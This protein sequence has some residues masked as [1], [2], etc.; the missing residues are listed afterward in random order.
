MS[1]L[2]AEFFKLSH[3]LC[4][5][6]HQPTFEAFVA[7]GKHLR[8]EGFG[9]VVLLVC[10]LGARFVDDPRVFLN[11]PDKPAH[12][13]SAGWMWFNPVQLVRN[14]ALADPTLFD[15]QCIAVSCVLTRMTCYLTLYSCL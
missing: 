6:L 14:V 12:P 2:I 7:E 5:L 4:P 9:C 11:H 3:K 15:L 8:E 10:A 13:H 1:K